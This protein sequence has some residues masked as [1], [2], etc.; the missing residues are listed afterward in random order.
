MYADYDAAP[1]L[2]KERVILV[3]GAG[4]GIGRAIALSFAAHGATVVL[5]G[6]TVAKL[7]S[8]YDE[9]EAAGG[10]TPA[11]YPIHL[12]GATP[13]DYDE[14]AASLQQ[15]FGRLDG[16]VHNAAILPYLA[17]IKDYE[18]EDWLKVMQ[19][20]LNAPFEITQICMPLLQASKDASVIFTTD[21]VGH[22]GKAFW[23]AYGV[24]KFGIEGLTQILAAELENSTV[25][26]NCID[27][28]A[29]R[30]ALRKRA[31]PAEDNS[32]LKTPDAL[33]PLYLWAI[34]PDSKGTT[35]KRLSWDA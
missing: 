19:V 22:D 4:E 18:I 17:R 2:L 1:D 21:A 29:T 26:V 11:I 28:G 5:L 34:G 15:A 23:G 30:T 24:S 9:I 14:L 3:T 35:G 33:A 32:V 7:E 12:E 10:P 31:F 20:N 13:H 16:I 27:P 8:V 6:K 25:R